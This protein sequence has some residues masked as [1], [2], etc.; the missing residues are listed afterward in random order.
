CV[1]PS[2]ECASDWMRGEASAELSCDD[3]AA[4]SARSFVRCCVAE[5][6]RRLRRRT[7]RFTKTTPASRIAPTTIHAIA[8]RLRW[9]RRLRGVALGVALASGFALG[10]VRAGAATVAARVLAN[11]HRHPQTRRSRARV[12]RDLGRGR[13]D[14]PPG[15]CP[16]GRRGAAR[17]DREVGR[18]GAAVLAVTEEPLHD[19]VL[20]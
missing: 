20:E 14:R 2:W 18:A 11:L 17:A 9:R 16:E 19:P 4:F 6:R 7:A 5:S 12:A 3:R 13:S 8:A 15:N 1:S 10:R